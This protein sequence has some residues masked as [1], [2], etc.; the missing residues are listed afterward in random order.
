MRE[1]DVSLTHS[2]SMAGAACVTDLAAPPPPRP[3]A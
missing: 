2:H 1:I 3:A